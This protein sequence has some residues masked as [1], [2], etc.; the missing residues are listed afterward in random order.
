MRYGTPVPMGNPRR[1]HRHEREPRLAHRMPEPMTAD[2][3][4]TSR[5]VAATP[6][7]VGCHC[8]HRPMTPDMTQSG[9]RLRTEGVVAHAVTAAEMG[10][11]TVQ[12]ISEIAG[13]TAGVG[14][15]ITL[16]FLRAVGSAIAALP[17]P[18]DVPADQQGSLNFFEQMLGVTR[19][20]AQLSAAL[21]AMSVVN[22][23]A[24]RLES[25]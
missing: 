15:T 23:L 10:T 25:A 20:E 17:Q 4:R 5:V 13:R 12:I 7:T 18:V 11:P 21:R 1:G 24:R 19:A 8:D 22:D 2:S 6:S 9:W 16:G 3:P 14:L